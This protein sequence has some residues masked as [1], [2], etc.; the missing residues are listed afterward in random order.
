MRS[1]DV[2]H[3]AIPFRHRIFITKYSTTFSTSDN[4]ET[5]QYWV[6]DPEPSINRTQTR[7]CYE[8]GSESVSQSIGFNI[9]WVAW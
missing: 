5:N 9:M 1:I 6:I 4:D 2:N 3:S 7:I 8:Y